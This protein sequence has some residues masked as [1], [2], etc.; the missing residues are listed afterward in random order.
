VC[1][2][3]IEDR[4]TQ[5]TFSALGQE[6]PLEVKQGWDVTG[7]KREVIIKLLRPRLP[8]Y[9]IKI[10]GKT[11]IDVTRKGIDKAFGVKKI[12]EILNIPL[13]KMLFIGDSLFQGGNDY[14]V[15]ELCVDCVEVRNPEHTK[16][17]ISE[18]IKE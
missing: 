1:G 2:E 8:N 13:N 6:A 4:G 18:L 16:K 3:L 15:K 10:G 11:S 17:I 9:D 7:E 12:Q 5:I 14:S